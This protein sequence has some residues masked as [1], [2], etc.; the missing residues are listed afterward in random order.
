MHPAASSFILN[1]V[2]STQW[3]IGNHSCV[4][5]KPLKPNICTTRSVAAILWWLTV[6]LWNPKCLGLD[7][8]FHRFLAAETL[9]K[10]FKPP[11]LW[12]LS[13]WPTCKKHLSHMKTL[14]LRVLIIMTNSAF[15]VRPIRSPSVSDRYPPA[16]IKLDSPGSLDPY[17]QS[18]LNN[19]SQIHSQLLPYHPTL[20]LAFPLWSLECW[21]VFPP[22]LPVARL[23]FL[24]PKPH[25]SFKL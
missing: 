2:L 23:V 10:V 25:T 9:A 18:H 19:I 20:S 14:C 15:S 5:I 17:I 6:R 11:L 7:S 13:T 16:P 3:T 4:Y 21:N 12:G 1:L 8:G 24:E 22:D